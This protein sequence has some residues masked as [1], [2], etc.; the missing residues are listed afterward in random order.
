MVDVLIDND[1]FLQAYRKNLYRHVVWSAPLICYVFF[2][3]ETNDNLE[4]RKSIDG[5]ETWTAGGTPILIR[6]DGAG[7]VT[8]FDVW[9]DQWTADD[10]GTLIHI[11][12]MASLDDEVQ[13]ITLDTSDDSLGIAVDV[14]GSAVSTGNNRD[15]SGISITKARG[16]G[17][18]YI[19]WWTNTNNGGG[20]GHGFVQS[21]DGGATWNVKAD[22]ADGDLVDEIQLVYGNEADTDD[23]WMIYWDRSAEE[24]TLKVYDFSGDSW[25]ETL[26]SAG[27]T[28]NVSFLGMKVSMRHSDNH[29]ILVAFND[30]DLATADLKAWDI[31]SSVSITALTDVLTNSPETYFP[32]IMTNQQD[33]SIYVGYLRGGVLTS[34]VGSYFKKSTDGGTT[35]EAEESL[36]E[37]ADDDHLFLDAG[38][39]VGN[40]GGKW[41]PVWFNSDLRDLFTNVNNGVSIPAVVDPIPAAPSL[42]EYGQVQTAIGDPPVFGATILRS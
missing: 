7:Q 39:S 21:D 37:D 25:S 33:D 8:R 35:W 1:V 2:V 27:M 14:G 34:T 19:Q 18:L 32:C 17:Y 20:D 22:G 10:N 28:D 26:I 3:E 23:V 36:S 11:V 29:A 31:A 41:Q 12:S 9:Y 38:I 15:S 16:N 30:F 42:P 13:H 24:I 4:Y 6:D 40:A 5:G